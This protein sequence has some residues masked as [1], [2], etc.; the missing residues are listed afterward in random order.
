MTE[1]ERQRRHCVVLLHVSWLDLDIL[2]GW[3][4]FILLCMEGS[5]FLLPQDDMTTDV[6]ICGRATTCMTVRFICGNTVAWSQT[7]TLAGGTAGV[8]A[9]W[10]LLPYNRMQTPN[11][12]KAISL[13]SETIRRRKSGSTQL[14]QPGWQN[15]CI[16]IVRLIKN[17]KG[18]NH[19]WRCCK[20]LYLPRCICNKIPR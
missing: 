17:N 7:M 13:T 14:P 1:R 16:A 18:R 9:T 8:Q 11:F 6:D 19:D 2:H 12:R 10:S 5:L 20:R 4:I 3:R 15:V